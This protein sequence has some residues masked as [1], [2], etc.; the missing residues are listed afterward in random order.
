MLPFFREHYLYKGD[1]MAHIKLEKL[2]N[3]RDLGGILTCDGKRIKEKRL[4]RSETLYKAS[5][6]DIQKLRDEYQ[7]K[8]VVDFRT[9]IEAE[10]KPDPQIDG[11]K[12][13]FN[14]IIKESVMGIT[15]EKSRLIDVPKRYVGMDGDPIEYMRDMYKEIAF[16]DLAKKNYANFFNILLNQENGAV[17]W[18][19]SAGKDRVG[20]GTVLLLS[21][22]NVS[23]ET[24]IQDYLMTSYYFK[25]EN[26]KL[27]LLLKIGV[28]DKKVRSYVLALMDVKRE[29]IMA[30]FDEID[31][32]GGM[33]KFLSDVMGLTDEKREKLRKMY[34]E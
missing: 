1:N 21:A 30:V 24:I 34:L 22:L 10:Q 23:R 29:Y 28:R 32:Q 25:D 20:I 19:C 3:V 18:H 6:K 33:D 26:K 12:N 8:T 27:G 16:G 5:Q 13:I 11:V 14:P 9:T 31:K 7:L 2:N 4:I 15:R 17:L